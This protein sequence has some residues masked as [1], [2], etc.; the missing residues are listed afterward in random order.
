LPQ[1]LRSLSR[2]DFVW[3]DTHHIPVGTLGAL[4]E[5]AGGAAYIEK[6]PAIR[7]PVE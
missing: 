5:K 6:A 7:H 3:L 4:Q 2:Q 1:T